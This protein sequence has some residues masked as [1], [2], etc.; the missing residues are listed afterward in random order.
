VDDAG[1]VIGVPSAIVSPAGVSAGIGFAI[2]SAVV[3]KVVPALIQTGR[4]E[5]PW[6]GVSGTSLTPALATAMGLKPEQRAPWW[7]TW[8]P[9]ARPTTPACTAATAT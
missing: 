6:L 9:A 8:C 3:Q 1:R 4:Y 7:W 2:P 5:H